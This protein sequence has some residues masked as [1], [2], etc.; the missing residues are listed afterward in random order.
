ML[1]LTNE[2]RDAFDS[3]MSRGY[4]KNK[5][6]QFQLAVALSLANE[7]IPDE[8]IGEKTAILSVGQADPNGELLEAVRLLMPKAQLDALH[9]TRWL[10]RLAEHGMKII[11]K[12]A[13]MGGLDFQMLWNDVKQKR[14]R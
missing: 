3:F 13:E 4:F 9:E 12:N 7:I 2:T 8:V 10:E 5:M 1:R 14:I 6:G 11:I